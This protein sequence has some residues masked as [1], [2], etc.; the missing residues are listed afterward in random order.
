[1][2]ARHFDRHGE[3]MCL[4]Y[5]CSSSYTV[6]ME[7]RD[8]HHCAQTT[9]LCKYYGVHLPIKLEVFFRGNKHNGFHCNDWMSYVIISI[10][11]YNSVLNVDTEIFVDEDEATLLLINFVLTSLWGSFVI[12]DIWA[13]HQYCCF[14]WLRL[15]GTLVV[16]QN[17]LV[18]LHMDVEK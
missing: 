11:I 9:C 7:G 12:F 17:S 13:S 1:M 2:E 3:S 18:C 14:I 16:T 8:G 4:E 15:R 5:G 6:G 10:I